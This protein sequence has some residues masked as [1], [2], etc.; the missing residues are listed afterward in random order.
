MVTNATCCKSAVNVTAELTDSECP[1]TDC[2]Y[3]IESQ[4]H[5]AVK[6]VGCLGLI[7]SFTEVSVCHLHNHTGR[8][9]FMSEILKS[10][11]FLSLHHL[12]PLCIAKF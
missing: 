6:I 9:L 8:I 11:V 1:L 2:E 12:L 4:L 3:V 10:R 5:Q 7:F